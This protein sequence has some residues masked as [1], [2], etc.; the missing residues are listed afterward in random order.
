[1]SKSRSDNASNHSSK[2]AGR[3]V[4]VS[5]ELENLVVGYYCKSA[6]NQV[7]KKIFAF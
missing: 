4:L 1:M 6:T 7:G 2:A 3:D 5:Q